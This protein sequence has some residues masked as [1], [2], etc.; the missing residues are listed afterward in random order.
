MN[1]GN[2]DIKKLY[3][4]LDTVFTEVSTNR[5]ITNRP[6]QVD[7]KM[8]SFVVISLPTRL[9]NNL[10]CGDVTARISLFAKDIKNAYPNTPVLDTMY[11]TAIGCFPYTD[12][13]YQ[14]LTPIAIDGGGDKL[15]YHIWHIQ[16]R[17]LIK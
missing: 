4:T 2:Y 14:F 1:K 17:I 5:F 15:G 8:D 6:P 9:Y 10:G 16:F 12:A 7:A 11:T 13:S 3:Q